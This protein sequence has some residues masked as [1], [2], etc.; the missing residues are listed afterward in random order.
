MASLATNT[1]ERVPRLPRSFS[2]GLYHVSAHA[3]DLRHLY[4]ST[5]DRR[6]FLGRLAAASRRFDVEVVS[7]VLMGN[8]YHAIFRIADARLSA[9][10]QELHTGY[11]RHH[12]RVHGRSAHLFRAHCVAREIESNDQLLTAVRYLAR[13]PV[14]AG[15]VAKPL[16]WPWSS[17]RAHAGLEPP[18]IPLAEAALSAAFDDSPD[19]RR[20]YRALVEADD[21]A[22]LALAALAGRAI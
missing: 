12:N 8:H 10:L 4:L 17:A 21:L 6:N 3:S 18:P 14:E 9:A 5:D 22:E 2:E 19:W 7:Y 20:R 11:S 13:N 15:L 1:V 16:A